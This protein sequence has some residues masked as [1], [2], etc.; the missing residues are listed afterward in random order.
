MEG[1]GTEEKLKERALEEGAGFR[2]K[3]QIKK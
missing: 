3:E 2:E 1:E